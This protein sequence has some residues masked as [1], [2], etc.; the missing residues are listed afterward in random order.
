VTIRRTGNN[1]GESTLGRIYIGSNDITHSGVRISS[2]PPGGTDDN[3]RRTVFLIRKS[4]APTH[5][6]QTHAT[7]TVFR[8]KRKKKA[9][10]SS[11]SR[12]ALGRFFRFVSPYSPRDSKQH[13]TK[14]VVKVYISGI[15]GNK[16]ASRRQPSGDTLLL[17][18]SL[19]TCAL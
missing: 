19:L 10:P 9:R 13:A 15:S 7:K 16:E 5:L 1:N 14:M 3:A 11:L 4:Y 2:P 17:R 8:E 18:Y 12:S 6:G